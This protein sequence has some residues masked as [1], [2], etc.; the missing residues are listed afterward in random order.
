MASTC[1]SDSSFIYY[2][3]FWICKIYSCFIAFISNGRDTMSYCIYYEISFDSSSIIRCFFYAISAAL[4]VMFFAVPLSN[5]IYFTMPIL[6]ADYQ[7]GDEQWCAVSGTHQ[8]KGQKALEQRRQTVG[9]KQVHLGAGE[10]DNADKGFPGGEHSLLPSP[11]T[12]SVLME[13]SVVRHV[14][15][16]LE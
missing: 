2:D 9:Q 1:C 14:F 13:Q 15:S 4:F 6:L 5:V 12:N 8:A 7:Q 3:T 10:R 16:L 11:A